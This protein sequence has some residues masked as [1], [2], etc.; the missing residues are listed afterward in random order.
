[1]HNPRFT[2]PDPRFTVHVSRSGRRKRCAVDVGDGHGDTADDQ[3]LFTAAH[4]AIWAKESDRDASPTQMWWRRSS[5]DASEAGT[6]P[7]TGLQP[8]LPFSTQVAPSA[9]GGRPAT[10]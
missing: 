6:V 3:V 5:S 8:M 10:D 4:H 1:M 2:A 9:F 7:A